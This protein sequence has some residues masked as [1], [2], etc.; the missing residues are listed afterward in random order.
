H[1]RWYLSENTAPWFFAYRLT[2]PLYN[3]QISTALEGGGPPIP[4][5]PE[6]DRPA[7]D[8]DGRTR[9]PACS[10]RGAVHHDPTPPPPAPPPT[11]PLKPPP[12]P[13]PLEEG[14]LAVASDAGNSNGVT[15]E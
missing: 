13:P 10:L 12:P 4:P 8:F 6:G 14:S 15:L 9:K 7:A 2:R 1:T 5:S 3:R 11:P